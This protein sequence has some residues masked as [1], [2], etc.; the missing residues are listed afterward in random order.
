[1]AS[2]L[3]L[4][5]KTDELDELLRIFSQFEKV[6]F[7]EM[8]DAMIGSLVL[9]H[10][11]I[12]GRTPVGATGNLRGSIVWSRTPA[13]NAVGE[14]TTPLRYGEV[15]ERGRRPGKMPPTDPMESLELWVIRK[16]GINPPA[17]RGVAFVI[18]RKIAKDGTRAAGM[19]AKGLA[20]SKSE[21]NRL[22]KEAPEKAK[23]KI[24]VL[25]NNV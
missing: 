8:D 22:W 17:S 15:V 10:G 7:D 24:E 2:E 3:E 14:V 19:F 21:I 1:M 16:L 23:R 11:Q 18:A 20:A 25:I 5:L 9:L 6:I 12:V 4:E 13:P